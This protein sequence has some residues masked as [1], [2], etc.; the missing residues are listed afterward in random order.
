M[1]RVMQA[2]YTLR[3]RHGQA[4]N[5]RE[6]EKAE[7]VMVHVV[8]RYDSITP[9]HPRSTTSPLKIESLS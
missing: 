6:V 7:G 3:K 1:G 2:R 5:G 8:S 9:P 4:A